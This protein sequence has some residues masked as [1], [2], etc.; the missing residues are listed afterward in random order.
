[1]EGRQKINVNSIGHASS[2][3]IVLEL[4]N[5]GWASAE[6]QPRGLKEAFLCTFLRCRTCLR[7]FDTVCYEPHSMSDSTDTGLCLCSYAN[8]RLVQLSFINVH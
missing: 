2:I 8:H 1:M 3:F 4:R 7:S 5:Q 6:S